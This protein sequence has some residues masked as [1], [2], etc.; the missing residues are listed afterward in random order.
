[1]GEK[2]VR[3]NDDARQ[4]IFMKSKRDLDVLPPTHSALELH[5]TRANYQAKIWLQTDHVI[6]KLENKLKLL[7]CGKKVQTD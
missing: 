3:G 2:D 5:I 4:S 7:T 1:M 6:I